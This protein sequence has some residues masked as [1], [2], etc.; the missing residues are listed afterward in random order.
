MVTHLIISA[1]L[2]SSRYYYCP[3]QTCRLKRRK[4]ATCPKA[5]KVSERQPGGENPG[6]AIP[7]PLLSAPGGNCLSRPVPGSVVLTTGCQGRGVGQH[8][9]PRAWW[10]VCS[11]RYQGRR[12]PLKSSLLGPSQSPVENSPLLLPESP[13]FTPSWQFA[14]SLPSAPGTTLGWG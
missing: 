11:C 1:A 2:G 8:S 6:G 13:L 3:P 14:G 10:P 4:L 7:D 5:A 12:S 9:C